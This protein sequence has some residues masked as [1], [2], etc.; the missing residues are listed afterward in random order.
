MVNVCIV[1]KDAMSSVNNRVDPRRGIAR[2]TSLDGTRGVRRSH[3]I[4]IGAMNSH[5]QG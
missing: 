4:I 3:R 2:T 5:G 1:G